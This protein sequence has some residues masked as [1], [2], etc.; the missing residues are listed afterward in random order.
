MLKADAVQGILVLGSFAVA[1]VMGLLMGSSPQ[2]WQPIV[3]VLA[4]ALVTFKMRVWDTLPH[5]V[6]F[7]KAGRL[8]IGMML[9]AI[10]GVAGVVVSIMA[11]VKPDGK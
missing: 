10:A 6:D 2:K 7:L 8:G 9:A 5:I 4:F 1:A 3:A 11:I